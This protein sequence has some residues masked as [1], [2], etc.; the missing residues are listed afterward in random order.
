MPQVGCQLL[1]PRARFQDVDG[2]SCQGMWG[3]IGELDIALIV[4][5][6]H[7]LQQAVEAE[8]L[9]KPISAALFKDAFAEAWADAGARWCD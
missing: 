8:A 5:N 2:Q 3:P 6:L 7:S 9:S 1:D 4:T